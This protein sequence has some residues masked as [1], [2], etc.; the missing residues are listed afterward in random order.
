VAAVT[1]STTTFTIT[2]PKAGTFRWF[3]SL[4]CD[5]GQGGWAMT[6]DRLGEGADQTGFMAGIVTVL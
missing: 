4:P 1:P 5:A 3:C 2:F 6:T